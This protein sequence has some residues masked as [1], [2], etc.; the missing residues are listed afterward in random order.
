MIKLPELLK[1]KKSRSGY[2][3]WCRKCNDIIEPEVGKVYD[4]CPNCDIKYS[5]GM[6]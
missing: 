1:P 3:L 2:I 5:I 6:K 4:K